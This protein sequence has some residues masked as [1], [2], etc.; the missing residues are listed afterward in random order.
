MSELQRDSPRKRIN[1][2]EEGLQLFK[3]GSKHMQNQDVDDEHSTGPSGKARKLNNNK[4]VA[5]K[6]E[7]DYSGVRARCIFGNCQID[8]TGPYSRDVYE[9]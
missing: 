6:L 2:G 4:K 9:P 8:E 7:K 1:G 5:A 3:N